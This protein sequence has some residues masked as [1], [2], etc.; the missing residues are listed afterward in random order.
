MILVWGMLTDR[1]VAA[2][3]SALARTGREAFLLDQGDISSLAFE[4]AAGGRSGGILRTSVGTLDLAEVTAAYIRPFATVRLRADRSHPAVCDD[5][6]LS[7]CDIAPPCIVNRPEAM[8]SNNAKPYQAALIHASGFAVPETIVT[9]DIDALTAFAERHG[10]LIYKSASGVRSIV[11][12]YDPRD[13]SRQGDLATCP[14]QFQ[15]WIAGT[16]V[17]VHVVRDEVFACEVRSTAI[18]YRYPENEAERP[19]LTACTLP[20][21]IAQRCRELAAALSLDFAGIDLRRTDQGEFV[22]FEVNP[23][24]GFTYY[25]D[26]TGLPIAAA[27]ADLLAR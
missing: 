22:C 9:N 2:V 11:A 1:P 21:D 19:H 23:S 20:A 7:W 13:G 18:D 24:P 8:A 25:E 15:Q 12:R 16:D 27:L 14:T 5:A 17:R 26:A 3:L 6:L 4:P 10:P